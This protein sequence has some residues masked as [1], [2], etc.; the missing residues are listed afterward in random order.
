MKLELITF[1][2]RSNGVSLKVIPETPVEESLIR[3]LW[4][5]GELTVGYGGH[6]I[7]WR[8]DSGP[9]DKNLAAELDTLRRFKARTHDAN[10]IR[11]LQQLI[12][13]LEPKE[14]TGHAVTQS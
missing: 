7:D 13:R 4:R 6:C 10:E 11:V 1:C 12:D 2:A 5:H 9:A 14:V 8:L 3:G